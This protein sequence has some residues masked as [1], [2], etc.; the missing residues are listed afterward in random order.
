MIQDSITKYIDSSRSDMILLLEKL[1]NTDS[2]SYTTAG[3]EKV[4]GFI[5][6]ILVPLKFDVQMLPGGKYAPHLLACRKGNGTKKIMFL[7]HMDTV[8]DEGTARKRPFCIKGDRAYGPGVCDMQAGIVCLLYA[9]KALEEAGFTDY[10]ELKI[11]FNSDE[12]RGSETSEKYIIE[13]CQKSDMVLV[14]EPGMPDD[15]VVIERQGGGIFNLDIVG[16][17]AHAG[18]C[19]LDGI[20]AIDE[21]AHKILAFHGLTDLS[22]G[23]SVS[24]GVINGGTRS[25]IIPEHVFMEIDLRAR[26]HQDG[27]ELM[28]KMQKIADTSYVP[29]TKSTLKKV[30]YRPPIEKTPGNA[31][32]YRTLT[33]AARKLGITVSET[34]CGGGSDGNYTSAE[35][36]PTID[37]L[38]PVG[39]LEHTDGEYMLIETLFSRCKLTALFIAELCA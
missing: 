34:Y 15:Y 9:L 2:G 16:K 31:A 6:E 37:S 24:V 23:R 14:M 22:L 36:I 30:M 1:V 11:L 29:G 8:F 26:S 13:E 3:V 35:G 17:P 20:H 5:S 10:G 18:A 25:N 7:G 28:E 27:L 4:A 38:G 39:S 21:A 12:E 19:P 32:L 33:A